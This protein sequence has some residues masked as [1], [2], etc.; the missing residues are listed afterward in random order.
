[1]NQSVLDAEVAHY[2]AR[3]YGIESRTP[4]QVVLAKQR[5]IGWFWNTIFVLLTAGLWLI[6][7]IYRLAN[8]KVDR[9]VLTVDGAGG[10]RR[11]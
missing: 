6:Y 1:M 7:V 11:S 3:G 10:V 2:V 9:V 4:T 5:R 8:R